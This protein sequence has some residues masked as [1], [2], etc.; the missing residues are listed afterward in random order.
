MYLPDR[1]YLGKQQQNIAVTF[2]RCPGAHQWFLNDLIVQEKYPRG[3]P[4]FDPILELTIMRLSNTP[5]VLRS[6]RGSRPERR[7]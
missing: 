7:H 2:D 6:A 4:S 3:F 5:S 1:G